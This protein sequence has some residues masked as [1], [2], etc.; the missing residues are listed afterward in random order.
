MA[1]PGFVLFMTCIPGGNTYPWLIALGLFGFALFGAAILYA[2]FSGRC[3]HCRR[4]LGRV[5]SQSGGSPFSIS[6]DLRF[7]PYCGASI[8]D[9]EA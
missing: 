2:M 8:D 9:E 5:F 6:A 1:I 7:C 3:V 4:W